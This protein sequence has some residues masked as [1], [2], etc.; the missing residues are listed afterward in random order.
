M[1]TNGRWPVYR[2]FWASLGV[3]LRASKTCSEVSSSEVSKSDALNDVHNMQK[4]LLEI[5]HVVV[6]VLII[7]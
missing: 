5:V 4:V 7:I 6:Q 2:Q 1:L 3:L